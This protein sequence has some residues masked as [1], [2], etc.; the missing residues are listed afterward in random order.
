MTPVRL[1]IIGCGGFARHHVR[2]LLDLPDAHIVGI[3]DT[4]SEQI[5]RTKAMDPHF[6]TVPSY[7]DYRDLL[8]KIHLD[9]VLIVTPHTL[10]RQQILDAFLSGCHVLCEKP[11]V[12]SVADAHDVIAA[13]EK[14]QKLGMIS[15]QRHLQ[16]E[17]RFIREKIASGEAGAVLS[18]QALLSQEWKRFTVGTWR[19][20]PALSG[21]GQLNDS[22][23]HMLDV[24]LWMTG[25]EAESVCAFTDNRGTE[26][27]INSTVA[28]RFK[29]GAQGSFCIVGDA[30]H[31]YEDI[32]VWCE[33]ATFFMRN[34]RLSWTDANLNR[35]TADSTVGMGSPD[36]NFLRAIRGEEEVQVPF[37]CGLRVIEL[38]EAAWRSAE[39]N[40]AAVRVG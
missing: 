23:S 36:R 1:G 9:A 24:I 12:T 35:W 17:F 30:Q 4:D 31:W 26:V 14:A 29:N 8:E 25:L 6:E 39:Q 10:H 15:Y 20:D 7:H 32:T 22:G 34:G 38:T 18:C 19:Q 16:G 11:L 28:V 27:D 40:G 37:E 2:T 13:R 33:N 21:G 3:A 5:A